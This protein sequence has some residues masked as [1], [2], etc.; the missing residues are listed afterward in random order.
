MELKMSRL[1]VRRDFLYVAQGRKAVRSGVVIQARDGH[2][3]ADE[4][5]VGFTATRKIGNAVVRNRA[6]RRLREAARLLLPLHGQAGNDYVFVARVTTGTK[7]WPRLLDD[8]QSALQ[9]LARPA[10][11][12]KD[13]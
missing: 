1:L 9:T 4:I 7:A 8:V 10:S 6:K 12:D 3:P 5:R 13:D 11:D 2:C